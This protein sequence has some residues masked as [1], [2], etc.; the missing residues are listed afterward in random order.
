MSLVDSTCGSLQSARLDPPHVWTSLESIE[1]GLHTLSSGCTEACEPSAYFRIKPVV[2]TF[3]TL[4]L[5]LLVLP[6]LALVSMLILVLDG[7]PI[8]YRQVRVGKNHR[9]FL[10]WKFRTMLRDAEKGIGP[11]WSTQKDAR[12]TKL[13][14]WLRATHMDELPQVLNIV[15]GHMHLVGPR[16][17]RPEFV[18]NLIRDIPGY[19]RRHAVRPGITGLAQ[20]KQGYDSCVGDVVKKVALDVAYIETAS[21]MQDLK[22]LFL[23]I[24]Y[25]V[26]EVLSVMQ[27]RIQSAKVGESASQ[28]VEQIAE[29]EHI[30]EL[31]IQ[32]EINDHIETMNSVVTSG[33]VVRQPKSENSIDPE[34]STEWI[35][36]QALK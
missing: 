19:D 11:V 14:R 33:S 8:F 16:P 27:R 32:R 2:E 9:H 29:A 21:L 20:V 23:T 18:V 15:V 10:I 1:R 31:E 25:I 30:L 35:A 13:G 22:I 26:G 7:R 5:L 17:E 6:L 4:L 36:D 24:P 3:L 34:R 28:A 12:V